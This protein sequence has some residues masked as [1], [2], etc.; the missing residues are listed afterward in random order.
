MTPARAASPS[1][2]R[3]RTPLAIA[4]VFAVT[5]LAWSPAA[6]LAEV[7]APA[8]HFPFDDLDGTL[9]ADASPNGNHG[10]ADG[11]AWVDGVD[12]GAVR[13]GGGSIL[14]PG[15]P[16]LAL[17]R[18]TFGAW[19]RRTTPP[20]GTERIFGLSRGGCDVAYGLFAT[21]QGIYGAVAGTSAL[22]TYA[23]AGGGWPSALWDGQWHHVAWVDHGTS[24][25]I[26]GVRLYP[27]GGTQPHTVDPEMPGD[28][29]IGGDPACPTQSGFGGDI[30][31]LRIYEGPVPISE[32]APA[33][34]ATGITTTVTLEL[35]STTIHDG[36]RVTADIAVSPSPRTGWVE[37][38]RWDG[39]SWV[40][41]RGYT[42]GFDGTVSDLLFSRDLP[43]GAH[44]I[45]VHYFAEG[46]YGTSVSP[47]TTF[48]RILTPT[49]TTVEVSPKP[50]RPIIATTLTATV[51][52]AGEE[53]TVDFYEYIG[54]AATKIG[55][56]PL[57]HGSVEGTGVAALSVGLRPL[58]SYRYQARYRGTTG[59][60]PSNSSVV[61]HQVS[62]VVLQGSLD[63]LPSIVQQHH[64]VVI[65]AVL[66]PRGLLPNAPPSGMWAIKDLFGGTVRVLA[67]PAAT[68][69][70]TI[71]RTSFEV[72]THT[73]IG[74]Y[75]GD[76]IYAGLTTPPLTI[77]VTPDIVEAGGFGM[78]F[79]TFYPVT[80][81][82]RDAVNVKGRLDEEGT[83]AITIKNGAGKTV[84]TLSL[85]TTVGGYGVPWNGRTAG[86]VLQPAGTYSVVQV[87]TDAFGNKLTW[88]GTVNLSHK[89]LVS[90]SGTIT[91]YANRYRTKLDGGA[92]TVTSTSKYPNG[93]RIKSGAGSLSV[94]ALGYRF[95]LPEAPAYGS[96]RFSVLASGG[97][98]SAAFHDVRKGK[99]P[100][101]GSWATSLF[102]PF[103]RVGTAY[104]WYSVSGSSTYN[105]DG[106]TVGAMVKASGWDLYVSKVRLTYTIK[107]LQ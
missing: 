89:K 43:V 94:A 56:A 63:A 49:T 107:V 100:G 61:P 41:V 47:S 18:P 33:L 5:L 52:G 78:G 7:A 35:S 87:V 21:P 38:E 46:R 17:E 26:D 99:L 85:G 11:V 55:S 25:Y 90:K 51:V 39:A 1:S 74:V 19:V 36:Q 93:M 102:G 67:R 59:K 101:T 34:A 16:T 97:P 79:G 57:D 42:L 72:G 20:P 54:D 65:D 14:V 82:Y 83:V 91:L 103:E 31:D 2:R 28:L 15:D 92:A 12:A 30:D 32:I 68:P 3:R 73:L 98:G 23:V 88:T 37:I 71:E 50:G 84:R 8:A 48:E 70:A 69:Y 29:T 75:S 86:G 4:A 40:T 44:T 58:G 6:A 104:G 9:V 66:D 53:G 105:R 62:K 80:D 13:P 77:T 106:R 22:A 60:A 76:G 81:G 24:F 27:T 96:M 10:T 64:P 45:R 95:T